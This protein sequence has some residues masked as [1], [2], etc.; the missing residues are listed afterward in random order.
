MSTAVMGG[1]EELLKTVPYDPRFPN[2]NQTR[3]NIESIK[4]LNEKLV[5]LVI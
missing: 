5:E 1:E 2:M 4:R 3:S